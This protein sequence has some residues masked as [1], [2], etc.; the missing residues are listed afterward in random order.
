MNKV[1]DVQHKINSSNFIKPNQAEF[2]FNSI[3]LSIYLS[4]YIYIHPHI[5]RF[6]DTTTI[7]EKNP[8]SD[9]IQKIY[10]LS[11]GSKFNK[12]KKNRSSHCVS[13]DQEPNIMS[14]K[15]QVQ[16]LALLSRLRIQLCCKLWHSSQRQLGSDVAVAVVQACSC[17]SNSGPSLGT[18]ICHRYSPKKKIKIKRKIKHRRE[19]WV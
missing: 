16:S 8:Y 5:S 3:Y 2:I 15:M 18:S 4:I 11:Y 10:I 9:G 19:L 12:K 14:M 6:W 17:S 13:V 1:P 7:T